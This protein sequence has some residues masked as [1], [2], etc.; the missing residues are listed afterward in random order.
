MLRDAPCVGRR[1]WLQSRYVAM[2]VSGTT[3]A[4]PL[5]DSD[6]SWTSIFKRRSRQP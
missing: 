1:W 5:R 4:S 2:P 6:A 3:L